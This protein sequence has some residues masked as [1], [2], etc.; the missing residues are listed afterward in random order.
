MHQFDEDGDQTD[1]HWLSSP[2][3]ALRCEGFAAP[4]AS[5]P[6]TV[7]GNRR[8]PLRAELFDLQG[9]EVGDLRLGASPAIQVWF[10]PGDT[11]AVGGVLPLGSSDDDNQF[12]YAGSR[13]QLN[14]KT[15]HLSSPGTYTISMVSGNESEYKIYSYST[16]LARLVVR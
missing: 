3:P 15:R 1:L 4:V 5:Y 10:E 11:G 12:A 8:L 14:L 9:F 13:W 16:C 2:V 7:R 6:V